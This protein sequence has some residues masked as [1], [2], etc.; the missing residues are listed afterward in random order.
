MSDLI[1]NNFLPMEGI[2]PVVSQHPT[3]LFFFFFNLPVLGPSCSTWLLGS[4][5]RHVASSVA[6]S[7]I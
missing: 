7:G 4:L 5:V 1:G 2:V 6:I 3:S